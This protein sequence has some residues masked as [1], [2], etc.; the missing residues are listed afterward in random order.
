MTK[1]IVRQLILKDW[2]LNRLQLLFSIGAG[3]IAMSVALRGGEGPIV[4]GAVWFFIALILVGTML[5]FSGIVNERKK[6]NL[7]FLMSLPVSS[8]QYT[9]AKLISTVG[10]F[11]AP[12]VTLVIT[13]V[14]LIETRR[15]VPPG[16]IPMVLILAGLPFV[17]LCLLTGAALI[18][19]SEGWGIAAN[20]ACNSSY[21]LVWYFMGR[22]P[23]LMADIKSPVPVWNPTVLKFLGV[24][25]GLIVLI[26]GLTFYIQSRKRDFV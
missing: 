3:V 7:A 25:L 20:V 1:S 6:Q 12:W 26:L 2:R 24:E 16:A 13:A 23:G 11:L 10:M 21:G 4:V 5:P 19:E 15:I 8:I 18:G 22:I 9:M 14:V 17:G